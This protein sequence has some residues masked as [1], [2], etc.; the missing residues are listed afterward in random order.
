M[1]NKLQGYILSEVTNKLEK[2]Y[3]NK[4]KLIKNICKEYEAYL[5]ILRKNL[6]ISVEK[7][8]IGIHSQLS[9][10]GVINFDRII[11]L[12]NKNIDIR[13]GFNSQIPFL[14]LELSIYRNKINK[15]KHNFKMLHKKEVY[16]KKKEIFFKNMYK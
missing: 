1:N 8:I 15:L 11:K 13:Q 2:S 3:N 9:E 14:T 10:D 6:L 16:W 7:G 4:E 12:L 5:I